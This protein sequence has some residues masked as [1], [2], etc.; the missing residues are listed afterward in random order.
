M[1]S[2]NKSRRNISQ[3]NMFDS[4]REIA[5]S[6]RNIVGSIEFEFD[7][8]FARLFDVAVLTNNMKIF[9]IEQEKFINL[10]FKEADGVMSQKVNE[11]DK[12]LGGL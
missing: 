6:K 8:R 2:Y 12:F 5:G 10:Y 9:S 1:N 7:E 3:F 11:F 4:Y